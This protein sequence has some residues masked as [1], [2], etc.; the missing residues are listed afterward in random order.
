MPTSREQA[1]IEVFE[2][3]GVAMAPSD[4]AAFARACVKAAGEAHGVGPPQMLLLIGIYT[5]LLA[6][7]GVAP[8][9]ELAAFYIWLAYVARIW[10]RLVKTSIEHRIV[11][12]MYL[13]FRGFLARI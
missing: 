5:A 9:V 7:M 11:M 4:A 10:T 8:S 2:K 1:V 13:R 12:M 6:G 3:H